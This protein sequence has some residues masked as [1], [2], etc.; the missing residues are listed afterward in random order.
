MGV[1][2]S[3]S[4]QV[5]EAGVVAQRIE[6]LIH[7]EYRNAPGS[8]DFLQPGKG[9]LSIAQ[10]GVDGSDVVGRGQILL[11]QGEQAGQQLL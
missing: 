1:A 4:Q 11:A 3:S 5:G 8:P 9:L 10:P 6:V 2:V 7:P